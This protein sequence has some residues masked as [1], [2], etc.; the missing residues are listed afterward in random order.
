[1]VPIAFA[2]IVAISPQ[3]FT[4]MWGYGTANG[5]FYIVAGTLRIVAG[6][7]SPVL[8]FRQAVVSHREFVEDESRPMSVPTKATGFRGH[9]QRHEHVLG[10]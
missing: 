6:A 8:Y 3:S 10:W 1:M 9:H 2:L 5:V 7:I 4:T